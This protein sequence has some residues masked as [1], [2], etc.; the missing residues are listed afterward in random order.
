M[1]D[2]NGEPTHGPTDETGPETASETGPETGAAGNADT[3]GHR[4]TAGLTIGSRVVVR[5]RLEEGQGAAATDFVGELV[6]RNTDFLILDTRTERVKLIRADVLAAKDVPPPASRAGR[7]HERVSADDLEK[8]MAKGWQAVDRS[9]LGDWVLRASGGF[10]GRANSALVV[11]DPSLPLDRAID[12]TEKWYADR[13]RPAIFQVHGET[14]FEPAE[15]PT[16]A[17]LLERGYVVG[18]GHESWQRVLVMTGPSAGVPP[19]TGQSPPVT[20]DAQL[21]LDWLTAYAEQRPVV[22]GATEA[23]LTGSEGQLFLSVRDPATNAIIGLA[24]L[25]IHPGWA[26]IFGLWVHPG[27]RRTGVATTIVSAAAMVARE[28]NMPAMYIQVSGDNEAGVAFWDDLGF[29][30][31]HEYTYVA[32]ASA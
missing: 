1:P 9:G 8:L 2:M 25:A 30:V 23:V 3:P 19:L 24:R 22:P 4:L 6:A 16:V 21:Q 20:A 13:D 32:R 14:G 5:Y 27:H 11:G 12:F 7:P 15:Q 26:G 18:G 17:A 28:N 10:T 29:T 31:H